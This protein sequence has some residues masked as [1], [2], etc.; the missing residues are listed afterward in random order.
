MIVISAFTM[1]TRTLTGVVIAMSSGVGQLAQITTV[2]VARNVSDAMDRRQVIVTSVSRTPIVTTR[3]HASARL[4]G[5]TMTAIPMLDSAITFV[6]EDV[7]VHYLVRAH[8]VWK[9]RHGMRRVSVDVMK[10]GL[11]KRAASTLVSAV[12]AVKAAKVQLAPTV[13]AVLIT[14]IETQLGFVF[15]M[16]TGS[17]RAARYM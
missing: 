14:P 9:M 16:Q 8:T 1:L 17:E 7:Q 2:S 4:T 10:G 13:T 5:R 11:V 15:A 6:T 3:V 12:R